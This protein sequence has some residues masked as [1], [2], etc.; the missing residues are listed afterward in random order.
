MSPCIGCAVFARDETG[1]DLTWQ[2]EWANTVC[3]KCNREFKQGDRLV[4]EDDNTVYHY[5]C[6]EGDKPSF[7]EY[8]ASRS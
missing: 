2:P 5:D 7:E 6:Y 3:P 4:V 8:V 1:H